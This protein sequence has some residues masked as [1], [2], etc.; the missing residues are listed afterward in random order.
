VQ[1]I[2]T[3]LSIGTVVRNRYKVEGL[4][5]KGGFGAVYLVR[6]QRVRGNLFAL[7]ELVDTNKQERARFAFECEVLTRLDYPSLPRVYR[8]FEDD[9]NYRA[10]MLMDYIEGP[11]LETLRQK[12]PEKRFS[13]LEVMSIMAPI[14]NAVSYLHNQQPPIIHRD[15]KPANIIVPEGND[16]AMLVDFG[17]AKEYDPEST[18]TAVRRCSPGYGAP[19]QYSRGTNTQTDMYGLG[20]TMYALLTGVVP[21]DAFYRMTTMGGH[22]VDPLEPVTNLVPSIPAHVSLAIQ[23]AMSINSQERYATADEFWRALHAAPLMPAAPITPVVPVQKRYTPIPDVEAITTIPF[24]NHAAQK[25]LVAARPVETSPETRT[26]KR[27]LL[28][29]ILLLLALLIGGSAIAALILP[30]LTSHS[31]ARTPTPTTIVHHQATAKPTFVPTTAPTAPTTA[32]TTVPTT[33][34]TTVPTTVPTTPPATATTPPGSSYPDVAGTYYGKAHNTGA[35][36]TANISVQLQQSQANLSGYVTINSPLEGSGS[37]INGFVQ[38]NNYIQFTVQGYAGNAPLLFTG[39][40]AQNGSMQG[41]YC[42]IDNTGHCN[43]SSGGY[44]TWN[45]SPGNSG[46]SFIMPDKRIYVPVA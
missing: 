35:N 9:A 45:V 40:V 2:Q 13:L 27:T 26:R 10:Y 28:P 23:K 11:N 21:A 12:Q 3:T 46:T 34:P 8:V 17:I 18:T 7:K 14:F 20:A 22:R 19:E 16:Q 37:I 24:V 4:L 30:G 32:P 42:S 1:D 29:I 36:V 41:Q 15:I 31:T 6:D 44:G 5:G 25:Q 39:S 33:A 38:N 43:S